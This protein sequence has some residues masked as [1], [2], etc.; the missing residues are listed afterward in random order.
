M[1]DN[2]KES[3]GKLTRNFDIG[4]FYV[5]DLVGQKQVNIEYCPTY[6]IIA[7]H[8]TKTLVGGKFKLFRD[9]INNLS[10][11]HHRIGHQEC[12]G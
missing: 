11:K 9:L 8:I 3:L 7:D 5:T 1:E 4:Y 6:E 10:D 2:G 12:V